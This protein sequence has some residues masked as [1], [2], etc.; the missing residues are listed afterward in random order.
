MQ[1]HPADLCSSCILGGAEDG[2]PSTPIS[3]LRSLMLSSNSSIRLPIS[4]S[5]L[6]SQGDDNKAHFHND[7][8]S[9]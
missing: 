9:T 4:S 2:E 6:Y 7:G 5:A 1:N 8:N 3:A